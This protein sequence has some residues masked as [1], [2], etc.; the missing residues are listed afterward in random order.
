M[1]PKD[2]FLAVD[3]SFWAYVRTLSEE[4]GYTDSEEDG[5]KVPTLPEITAA[6]ESLGLDVSAIAADSKP[7]ELGQK[8]LAYFAHRGASINGIKGKLMDGAA[9]ERTFN[10]VKR[11]Y[12][13]T[14]NLPMNKQ[15]GE[16][17]K[18]A[19]LTGIVT[20]LLEETLEEITP[21]K[22]LEIPE[23]A[24]TAEWLPREEVDKLGTQKYVNALIKKGMI[25]RERHGRRFVYHPRDVQQL[26]PHCNYDPR[27]LTTV[28]LNGQ[29]LRTLSRR[30]DG[31]YPSPVN[32]IAIWEIKEYYYTTSFGSRVADGIYET[33]LDGAELEDLTGIGHGVRHYLFVDAYKTWWEDGKSY[34]CR[35]VDAMHMGYVDEVLVGS[36]VLECIPRLAK[37][38]VKEKKARQVTLRPK[39]AKAA[40]NQA[41]E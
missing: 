2:D 4:I 39:D 17:K 16:K 19:F 28:T 36:E 32:P 18:Y 12:Q 3:K 5:V 20:M 9:A 26:K 13:Y 29:P 25:R 40:A 14:C 8:L 11:R 30:V 15:K 37:E 38:W 10:Q 27:I 35:L 31:A 24:S 7:T 6:L 23:P 41:N 21:L 22:T 33:L 34:L 1:K